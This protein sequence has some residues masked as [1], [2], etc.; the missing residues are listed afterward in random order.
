MAKKRTNNKEAKPEI[1]AKPIDWDSMAEMVTIVFKG[2]EVK[3]LKENA[4]VLI[5][6]KAAKLK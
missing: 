3:T 1:V 6:K 2:K 4:K 5:E